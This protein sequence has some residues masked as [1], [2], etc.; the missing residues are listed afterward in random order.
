MKNKELKI[1]IAGEG[2]QGVQTIAK[3]LAQAFIDQRWQVT[4]IPNF[5]VEQRGGVSIAFIKISQE[6]IVFP[7]F[8]KGEIVVILSPRSVKRT[9]RYVDNKT[10]VIYNS[11]FIPSNKAIKKV[12]RKV[13]GIPATDLAKASNAR[14]F[15]II[16][17]GLMTARLGIVSLSQMEKTVNKILGYKYKKRPRLKKLNE[18]ALSQGYQWKK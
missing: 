17:L 12:T 6:P 1:V 13:K 18:K 5:G 4:Y 10:L 7:K 11:S 14:V 2:G 3:I 16:I 8:E 9:L 15:N